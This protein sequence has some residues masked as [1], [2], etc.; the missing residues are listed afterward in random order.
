[1]AL[2]SP[3]WPYPIP[4]AAAVPGAPAPAGQLRK[5]QDPQPYGLSGV[6]GISSGLAAAPPYP[7]IL[8]S[9]E[10]DGVNLT[11]ALAVFGG[12]VLAP[13]VYTTY[14]P[15]LMAPGSCLIG[16]APVGQSV[17]GLA[18]AALGSR[19]RAAASWSAGTSPAGIIVADQAANPVIANVIAD[20]SLLGATIAD[21]ITL[22][23]AAAAPLIRNSA[24][25]MA[26]GNG[27]NF[28]NVSGSYPDGA[29]FSHVV[30]YLCAGNGITGA[31]V[32]SSMVNC[33]VQQAGGM[34]FYLQGANNRLVCCRADQS[35]HGFVSDDFLSQGGCNMLSCCETAGN[36]GYGIYAYNSSSNSNSPR[37]PLAATGC[38]CNGD[39][40][41][42]GSGGGGFAGLAA[43]GVSTL[44][45]HNVSVYVNTNNV[46]AGCPE[47]ALATA[48]AGTGGPQ[49]VEAFGGIWNCI[50]AG[51]GGNPWEDAASSA[52]LSVAV[53]GYIGGM[54]SGGSS[55]PLTLYTAAPL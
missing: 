47:Y 37:T 48:K 30:A 55:T 8:P 35:A 9:G 23:G 3:S 7:L 53:H 22:Y 49:L 46:S 45:A 43:Y 6:I 19:I 50:T 39:G 36:Q 24:V 29:D 40:V 17:N 20:G 32:D 52:L 27:I 2:F 41:N 54:Y 15:V 18:S 34:G 44:I 38:T 10:D 16:A 5:S 11:N 33:H 26:T 42:A 1:M 21:G 25:Y 28:V 31:I 14:T 12:V 13:L 4:Q 51:T